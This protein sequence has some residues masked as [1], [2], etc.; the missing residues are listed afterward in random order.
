MRTEVDLQKMFKKVRWANRREQK[1][2]VRQKLN[3]QLNRAGPVSIRKPSNCYGE[4]ISNGL[5]QMSDRLKGQAKKYK[6]L[7]KTGKPKLLKKARTLQGNCSFFQWDKISQVFVNR[8]NWL[9]SFCFI[10][11]RD[12]ESEDSFL[13]GGNSVMQNLCLIF[14]IGLV[15]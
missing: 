3:S 14:S 5:Q 12:H 11:W 10:S 9:T 8:L 4:W 6:E 13:Q 7:M 2:D 15:W 1:T